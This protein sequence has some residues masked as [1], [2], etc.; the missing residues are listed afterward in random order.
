M[1]T[2]ADVADIEATIT[3]WIK[4]DANMY[5][6]AHDLMVEIKRLRDEKRKA[7]QSARRPATDLPRLS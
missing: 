1:I 7:G 5:D 4:S 6:V 3:V 2:S